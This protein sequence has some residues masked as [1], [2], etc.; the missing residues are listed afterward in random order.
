MNASLWLKRAKEKISEL[1]AELILTFLF[2]EEDRIALIAH[3]EVELKKGEIML[4]DKMVDERAQ[5]MPL[6]YIT[7]FKEFYGRD[8]YVAET[9]LIPRVESET[10]ID[11]AK[12]IRPRPKTILDVGTGS[13]NLAVTL[14]LEMPLSRV[15]AC[16]ISQDALLIATENA[17]TMNSRVDFLASDLLEAYPKKEKFDLIV[18]NLPYVDLSWGWI[19]KDTAFEPSLALYA[20]DGGLEII[21]RLLE[22]AVGRAKRVLLE[23]DPCQHKRVIEFAKT[24]GYSCEEKFTREYHLV[25]KQAI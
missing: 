20:G 9:V 2:G 6:A 19:S 1:D 18:A 14:A 10:I 13:G 16:D 3:P 25:L 22:Q 12:E 8:F 11:I 5:G 21:K 4:L 17:F 15:S 24:L 7:R 23:C